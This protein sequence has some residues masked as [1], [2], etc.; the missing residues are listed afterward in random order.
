MVTFFTVKRASIIPTILITAALLGRTA[1]V[2][3]LS[4]VWICLPLVHKCIITSS[5]NGFG[6]APLLYVMN[7]LASV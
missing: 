4:T 2:L 5:D 6:F 1:I 3:L 7:F